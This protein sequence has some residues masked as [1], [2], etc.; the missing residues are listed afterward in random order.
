MIVHAKPVTNPDSIA[1]IVATVGV[2]STDAPSFEKIPLASLRT[3][4]QADRDTLTLMHNLPEPYGSAYREL[5]PHLPS[6]EEAQAE[7]D[8][9]A[10]EAKKPDNDR[11]TP[12]KWERQRAVKTAMRE[13][14]NILTDWTLGGTKPLCDRNPRQQFP[15]HIA[16]PLIMEWFGPAGVALRR[17]WKEREAAMQSEALLILKSEK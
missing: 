4:E 10:E 1:A 14:L 13:I 5:I 9:F 11:Y 15:Y 16:Q 6:A 12:E 17:A 2:A 8:Y 3:K 7:R